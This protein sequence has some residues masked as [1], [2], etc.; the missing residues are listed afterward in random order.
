MEINVK[1]K[2]VNI[3]GRVWRRKAWSTMQA[4][5]QY[6]TWQS[7]TKMWPRQNVPTEDSLSPGS[8][9]EKDYPCIVVN[10]TG[11]GPD[12]HVDKR[13]RDLVHAARRALMWVREGLHA[14]PPS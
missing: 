7:Q 12:E 9:F 1:V 6:P 4:Q 5:R 8:C 11:T 2:G 3:Q 10:H 14:A 13:I